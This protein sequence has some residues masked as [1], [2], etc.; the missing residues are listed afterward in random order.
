MF[1]LSLFLRV[2]TGSGGEMILEED[3]I[4]PVCSPDVAARLKVPGDLGNEAL[5]HDAIW[6]G[7]W[8]LW[9]ANAAPDLTGLDAG[10]SFSLYSVALEEA[11]NGAGV[12]MGHQCLVARALAKG[13][14][15]APFGPRVKTPKALVLETAATP[16][17]GDDLARVMTLLAG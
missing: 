8:A 10:P 13:E 1:D 9:A 17:P 4:F 5:L 12:L 3:V 16:R 7:D 15:V 11:K 2:P 14:L 6:P